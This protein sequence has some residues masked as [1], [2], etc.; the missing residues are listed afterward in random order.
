MVGG[1]VVNDGPVETPEPGGL[2]ALKE[3]YSL[4]YIRHGISV[5]ND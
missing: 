4:L 1:A 2:V 3:D 5:S